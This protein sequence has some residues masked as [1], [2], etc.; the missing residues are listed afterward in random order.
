MDRY[1]DSFNN[2]HG[3]SHFYTVSQLFSF[4]TKNI[5]N[6]SQRSQIL[7]LFRSEIYIYLPV[8]AERHS[9]CFPNI[10]E[11]FI[12][13][14][15]TFYKNILCS[16]ECFINIIT[17]VVKTNIINIIILVFSVLVKTINTFIQQ[18]TVECLSARI[19]N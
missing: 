6:S 19:A 7:L 15:L 12:G 11:K 1:F 3:Y 13:C 17:S 16:F 18:Q 4:F 10:I 2:K 8:R 9:P 14:V 5:S